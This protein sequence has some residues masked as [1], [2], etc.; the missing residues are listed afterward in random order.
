M[1]KFVVQF[2]PP[3]PSIL[4]LLFTCGGTV[5]SNLNCSNLVQGCCCSEIFFYENKINKKLSFGFKTLHDS[6]LQ[7]KKLKV[8]D[9]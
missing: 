2:E 8:K 6:T 4:G 1:S 9:H 5:L 7:K 3:P